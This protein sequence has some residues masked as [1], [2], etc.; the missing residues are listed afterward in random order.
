MPTDARQ[1]R[2]RGPF[3]HLIARF[4]AL[5]AGEL[6]SVELYKDSLVAFATPSDIPRVAAA[7]A[8]IVR[9]TQWSELSRADFAERMSDVFAWTNY[10]HPFRE[11]NGRTA[12]VFLMHVAELSRYQLRFDLVEPDRWNLASMYTL[13]D[14]QS[15]T[16]VPALMVP[17]FAEMSEL[18][19][20]S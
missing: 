17:V 7:A 20:R 14:R 12:K 15:T 6:R 2:R 11:D 5:W 13:P 1:T 18:R 19:D 3:R 9:S 8:Q 10:A 16:P 4:V